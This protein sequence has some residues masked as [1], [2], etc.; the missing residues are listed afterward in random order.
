V[1]ARHVIMATHLPLGQVGGYYAQAYPYAEPVVAAKIGRALE[2][3]YISVEQPSHSIRTHTRS[4]G[5]TYAIVAGSSFK[6]GQTDDERKYFEDIR[7][8]L[9]D[10]FKA[11]PV[12]YRWVNED[13]TSMDEMPF[14]GWSASSGERYLVATGFAA[15]GITN[16]TAAAMILADIAA[17]KESRWKDLFDATRIK[18]V[19]GGPTFLKENVG[20]AKHLVSGYLSRKL[21]SIDDLS[22]GEA[23]I[24]KINGE[25][26]AAFKDEEGRIYAVSAACSHMGCALGWNETDRTWDCA[27]H[28]SRF[29]LSGAVLHGPAAT[30]L[31][32]KN[33]R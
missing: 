7:C 5:E 33:P 8:W 23:A 25:D 29:D 32:P 28:G 16:G 18:P 9:A 26:V 15:W 19:A 17:G 30:P 10:N 13:Y 11:G 2:G 14:V 1:V 12:E 3:M 20:V 31:Q 6:P 22:A 21:K 24:L 4:D 27:C